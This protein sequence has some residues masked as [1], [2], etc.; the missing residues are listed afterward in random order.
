MY[1]THFLDLKNVHSIKI[2]TVHNIQI[3][4][5]G[6]VPVIEILE[7]ILLG[8]MFL[9]SKKWVRYTFFRS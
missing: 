3:Q 4:E 9:R 2:D 8:Y 1:R 6:K 7:T 5:E